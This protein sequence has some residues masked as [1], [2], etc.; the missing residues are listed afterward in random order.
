MSNKAITRYYAKRIK[1]DVVIPGCM[2]Q[3]DVGLFSGNKKISSAVI[4]GTCKRIGARAFFG[5]ENLEEV[6]LGE[7]VEVIEELAFCGTR[8][9]RIVIPDSVCVSDGTAFIHTDIDVPVT[10]ASGTRLIYCPADLWPV[11]G[12]RIIGTNAFNNASLEEVLTLPSGIEIIEGDAFKGCTTMKKVIVPKSVKLIQRRAFICCED[13]E[14]VELLSPETHV[15]DEAFYHC[16]ALKAVRQEGRSP[17]SALHVMGKSL[18]EPHPENEANLYHVEEERFVQLVRRCTRGNAGAMNAMAEFFDEWAHR[19]GASPFYMRAS[20]YWRY[21]AYCKRNT[22]AVRW[23]NQW[24]KENSPDKKLESILA[25]NDY[26]RNCFS[27]DYKG[28]MLIALGL[29]FFDPLEEYA[30]SYLEGGKI[31][32]VCRFYDDYP[33]DDGYG[34]EE[35]YY[36]WY[37]DE[38][39]QEIPRMQ[40]RCRNIRDKYNGRLD[41]VVQEAKELLMRERKGR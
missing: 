30:I 13:L 19:E 3:I 15:E 9:R 29:P 17:D 24:F 31:I 25:E 7:G 27:C 4:P 21:R 35:Y 38:N 1:G 40:R 36:F 33:S 32:E 26:E 12:I 2:D 39:F 16:S 41:E 5:C 14:T 10:N 23:F 8:I 11:S 20:N 6:I 34:A 28:S 18:L 22:K 37:L